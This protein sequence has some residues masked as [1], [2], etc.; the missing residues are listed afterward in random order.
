M[1][2]S[3]RTILVIVSTFIALFF[4][5]AVS[6]DIILLKSF[7][8]LER[9]VVAD[10]VQKVKNEIDE[11]FEELLST[12]NEFASIVAAQGISS[13]VN[14]SAFSLK[15]RN[16][17]VVLGY[18]KGKKVVVSSAF[19]QG[20]KKRTQELE[21]F[22]SKIV[23]SVPDS[24]KT[25]D[26][27]LKGV[28]LLDNKPIQLVLS[29]F[30]GSDLLLVVG[31][32]LD[33]NEINRV[34]ALTELVIDLVP[35]AGQTNTPDIV[36]ALDSISKG[37]DI[38]VHVIN[39]DT[40]IGYALYKDFFDNPIMLLKVTED[41]L[42]YKHGKASIIYVL[43]SLLLIGGV[44]CCVMLIYIRGTILN[45][46][47][48]LIKMTSEISQ[49]SDITVRIPKTDYKDELNDLS[50]S[51]N[52]MLDSLQCAESR[53][54]ESEERYRLLFDRAPDA[55][56]IIGAEGDEAG[57]IVAANQAAADLHGYT[58]Y[59]ILNLRVTDLNS[60]E[61][62]EI[63]GELTETVLSGEWLSREIWHLKKDGTQFPIEMHAGLIVV[64]GKKYI[65][66]FDRDIT[67]RKINEETNLMH[68]Q[69]INQLNDELNSRA[70]ELAAV[71][72]ELESFNYSVSHDMRGPLTRI[73]G[74]CQLLLDEDNHL[75]PDLKEYIARIYESGTW[76][77]DMIDAL[78]H[79][80]QLTRAD[81]ATDL[82]NL[83]QIADEALKELVFEQPDRI[84][85]TLV[86]PDITV[87]G[88]ARLLKMAMINLLGNAW[89]Y[90]SRKSDVMIEFGAMQT[91][92]GSVYFVRDNGDGF[93]MK[94]VSKLFRVFT[95]L[96]D[97]SKF[98]GTGIG[99]ATVQRIILR[100]GGKIW[101]EGEPG[102]GA[103]FYFTLP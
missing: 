56:I 25:P 44:F 81:I 60:E 72:G 53:V 69:Q 85:M 83:S 41:R 62:N 15:C 70:I 12:S 37:A 17:D 19:A 101:A 11:S 102:K 71:N 66:G 40:V 20:N 88:D 48:S 46:L 84:V 42:I 27:P 1:T 51:I 14:I 23:E 16:V 5:L 94:D 93:D 21:N 74:Y 54:R 28:F 3:Q 47:I 4:I 59:E 22:F 96:H 103:T 34:T 97:A 6:S 52:C 98:I 79:L 32:Y 68:F 10:N 45:R 87:R 90:S 65:L 30:H 100:H 9:D 18:F 63:V 80:S 8:S 75:D 92:S 86:E 76:L 29:T 95:R 50:D 61:T 2:L 58:L 35:V 43:C 99:L 39:S 64:D 24:N 73:S 82:V 49:Q 57:R 33:V 67:Q 89:K 26:I 78:L 38:P 77:N 91:E 13:I 55:I 31:R 7:A 36:V